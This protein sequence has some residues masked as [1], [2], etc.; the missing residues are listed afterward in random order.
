MV[1]AGSESNRV[2]PTYKEEI[3]FDIWQR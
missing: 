2:S 3:V 1:G